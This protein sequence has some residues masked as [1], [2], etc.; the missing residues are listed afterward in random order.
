MAE[1][2]EADQEGRA[3]MEQEEATPKDLS[4]CGNIIIYCHFLLFYYI[5]LY[6][7]IV[8]ITA[9]FIIVI[10]IIVVGLLSLVEIAAQLGQEHA[11]QGG[12][13]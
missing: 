2:D 3:R 8:I 9:I 13:R 12:R 7:I 10:V 1:W 4:R 5:I 11:K 6:R